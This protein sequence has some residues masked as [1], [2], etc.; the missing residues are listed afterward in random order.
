MFLR[1]KFD[2]FFFRTITA[3]VIVGAALGLWGIRNMAYNIHRLDN[4]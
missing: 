1:G 3:T 4:L 2:R